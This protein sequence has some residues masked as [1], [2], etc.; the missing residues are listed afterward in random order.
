MNPMWFGD[1]YDIVKRFFVSAIKDMG[2]TVYVE[3]M[4]TGDP[5]NIQDKFPEFIGAKIRSDNPSSAEESAIF[6]DPDTGIHKKKSKRHITINDFVNL[7]NSYKI[8]FSFDQSFPRN[9]NHKDAMME[10]LSELHNSGGIGFYYDS[11]A[12]FLFGSKSVKVIE[13]LKECFSELGLPAFRIIE[14]D[15]EI[16]RPPNEAPYRQEL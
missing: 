8:V 4:F 2:Y 3:P 10:K 16:G 9:R 1:S 13:S 12:K 11:H 5:S 6:I 15:S 7:L 14:L